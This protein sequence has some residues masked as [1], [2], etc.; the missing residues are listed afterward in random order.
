MKHT[1]VCILLI[2]LVLVLLNPIGYSS[3][4]ATMD[5]NDAQVTG[6]WYGY[7]VRCSG[8]AWDKNLNT[9][10][11]DVGKN[12]GRGDTFVVEYKWP[13][14]K[15]RGN[16]IK[17]KKVSV[18]AKENSHC[19]P[20][21]DYVYAYNFS[22]NKW[23][24]AFHTDCGGTRTFTKTFS[25]DT[26]FNYSDYSVKV[27]LTSYRASDQDLYELGVSKVEYWYNWFPRAEFSMPDEIYMNQTINDSYTAYDPDGDEFNATEFWGYNGQNISDPKDIQLKIGDTITHGLVACDPYNCTVITHNITVVNFQPKLS[28]EYPRYI[29]GDRRFK[30]NLTVGDLELEEQ[31]HIINCTIG[32]RTESLHANIGTNSLTTRSPSKEGNYIIRCK[33]CDGI[34]CT[35]KEAPITVDNTPPRFTNVSI[36]KC[37]NLKNIRWNTDEPAELLFSNGLNNQ[38]ITEGSI[39]LCVRPIDRAGNRGNWVCSNV[40][41]D[42]TPPA[43][44]YTN[45]ILPPGEKFLVTAIDTCGVNGNITYNN[46]TCELNKECPTTHMHRGNNT[47]NV[48]VM[49]N[50]GNT[51]NETI[52]IRINRIPEITNA[53]IGDLFA[54]SRLVC[55]FNVSNEPDQNWTY[56]LTWYK[57][58]ERLDPSNYILS[59]GDNITCVITTTD[60]L[61]ETDVRLVSE[62]V[63]NK[64]PELNVT[65]NPR[66]PEIGQKVNITIEVK[67]I[68]GDSVTW[69]ARLGNETWNETSHVINQ[70]ATQPEN[71]S[72][73]AS[74]WDGFNYT[75]VSLAIPYHLCGNKIVEPGEECDG[76]T[77]KGYKCQGCRLIKLGS[78]HHPSSGGSGGGGSSGSGSPAP[79]QTK[80]RTWNLNNTTIKEFFGYDIEQGKTRTYW[81]V[82]VETYTPIIIETQIPSE[83]SKGNP[84][85][86]SECEIEG[87][88]LRWKTNTSGSVR[89]VVDKELLMG[90]LM[91]FLKTKPAP[92]VKVT[93]INETD[94]EGIKKEI[95]ADREGVGKIE[96]HEIPISI[97]DLMGQSTPTAKKT[98]E[99]KLSIRPIITKHPETA[100]IS[101]GTTTVNGLVSL[102]ILVGG[103]KYRRDLRRLGIRLKAMTTKMRS[104]KTYP[105]R[106]K[107]FL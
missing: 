43:I 13:R 98:V 37:T 40:T 14:D 75:N 102:L 23:V 34:T 69:F 83:F 64:P 44:N 10:A 45:R 38:N 30:I 89:L 63:K 58:G 76:K 5:F 53:S 20:A 3:H 74:A 59:R 24:Y 72:L 84:D 94:E 42:F 9:Y 65:W 68:D 90:P 1:V 87:N 81:K 61:N 19:V 55:K 85:C 48:M 15:I 8:C 16:Y 88:L 2:V 93:S 28:I 56:N 71:Y 46:T 54:D 57:N 52:T 60:A 107:D 67:D 18:F 106:G 35:T 41:V 21:V 70:T 33:V 49:D 6:H 66:Y 103:F 17:V 12:N 27:K 105:L 22:E 11:W 39:T 79:T 95:N 86:P 31:N 101:F 92:N 50:A 97:N 99:T 78:S 29:Q 62:T 32:N 4:T 100:M 80:P 7:I 96:A 26:V 82:A 25:S 77:P 91:N 73:Y 36:P 104:R 47:V 51:V